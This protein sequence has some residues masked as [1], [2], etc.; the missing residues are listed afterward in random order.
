MLGRTGR[1]GHRG[2][3]TSF[4]N[5]R[6]ENIA[7]VLTRTLLETN[8]H[9]P[10]FL[11]PYKPEG[12]KLKFEA[13]SDFE[14]DADGDATNNDAANGDAAHGGDAAAEGGGTWGGAPDVPKAA[15][16]KAAN[17]SPWGA[18]APTVQEAPAETVNYWG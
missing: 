9:V 13:D 7:S 15:E 3:A 11:E 8:Q 18:P 4:Y 2:L 5:D 14:D 6:D 1:I 12:S 17:G 16:D 10:D